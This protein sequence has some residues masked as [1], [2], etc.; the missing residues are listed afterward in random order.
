MPLP[1]VHLSVTKK[2]ADAGIPVNDLPQF[3]LGSISPDAIHMRQGADRLAKNI[4]H[5]LP[6]EKGKIHS[7]EDRNED[8]YF[9]LM[10][11]FMNANMNKTNADF[12]MGYAAHILTDMLWTKRVFGKFA[13]KF[14]MSG[15]PAEDKSKTYYHDTDI[16]DYLIY[17]GSNWRQ[18]VW[19]CLQNAEYADF[20]DFLSAQEI[21]LWNERVLNW[22][23]SPENQYKFSGTPKYI[24]K[25]D[26]D[27]FISSCAEN[28]LSHMKAVEQV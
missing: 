18:D 26:I 20:L 5:L 23:V 4:T 14:N 10:R 8:E 7:W 11:D 22:Y 1:M 6:A 15:A 16:V 25:T 19:Q 2:L 24:T 27:N 9:E 12:L 28:I 13:E 17:S 3:Y 21:K